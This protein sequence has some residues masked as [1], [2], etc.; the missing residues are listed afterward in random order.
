MY[1][2]V[3]SPWPT[4]NKVINQ[5]LIKVYF[6]MIFNIQINF[7]IAQSFWHLCRSCA[8]FSLHISACCSNFWGGGRTWPS[9]I[10]WTRTG[11]F[12]HSSLLKMKLTVLLSMFDPVLSVIDLW[13]TLNLTSM[14]LT[15]SSTSS[16]A[17]TS[18]TLQPG[19]L[20][21]QIQEP[22]SGALVG[23]PY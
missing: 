19:R 7:E 4:I 16:L 12:L 1:V 2:Y 18:P 21:R 14:S 13:R 22:S 15:H 9:Q 17:L 6:I 3:I 11:M 5:K 20:C 8:F 23:N 10:M